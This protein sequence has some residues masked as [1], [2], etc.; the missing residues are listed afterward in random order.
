MSKRSKFGEIFKATQ[1]ESS[2]EEGEKRSGRPLAKRSDPE[3]KQISAF[4]RKETHRKAK[5]KLLQ[6]DG[7]KD[8]SDVIEE[9]LQNW[10]ER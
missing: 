8:L 5:M 7:N 1:S 10:V 4:V 6:Q 9:L 2:T 3:W